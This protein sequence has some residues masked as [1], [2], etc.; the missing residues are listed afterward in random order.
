ME[1]FSFERFPIGTIF[2]FKNHL[3]IMREDP[4]FLFSTYVVVGYTRREELLLACVYSQT[5]S[6][7]FAIKS[8]TDIFNIWTKFLKFYPNGIY[9]Y[10]DLDYFVKQGIRAGKDQLENVQAFEDTLRSKDIDGFRALDW[11]SYEGYALP[12]IR[13]IQ[14]IFSRTKLPPIFPTPIS[15]L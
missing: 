15:S 5:H 11:E 3:E 7:T 10:D 4:P 13:D 14:S 12:R 2:S 9:N 1:R 8:D 6:N